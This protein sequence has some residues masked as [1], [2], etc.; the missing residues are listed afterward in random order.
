LGELVQLQ[1]FFYLRPGDAGF[2]AVGA[3]GAFKGPGILDVFH[4]PAHLAQQGP[5]LGELL[6]ELRPIAYER[7]MFG[8]RRQIGKASD[9][10]KVGS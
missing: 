8:C 10:P 3:F 4:R 5:G 7:N 6:V 2:A 1:F 9:Q